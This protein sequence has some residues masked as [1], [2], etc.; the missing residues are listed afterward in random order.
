MPAKAHLCCKNG[1]KHRSRPGKAQAVLHGASKQGPPAAPAV[2]RAH[3]YTR[4]Q[5]IH[6]LL[7]VPLQPGAKLRDTQQADA[8]P[9]CVSWPAAARTTVFVGEAEPTNVLVACISAGSEG[10][11]VIPAP[12]PTPARATHTSQYIWDPSTDCAA[13][14]HELLKLLVHQHTQRS[15]AA[16]KEGRMKT[17]RGSSSF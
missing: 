5:V 12:M 13:H 3:E 1:S 16:H 2:I 7:I 15:Y 14:T 17:S 10:T 4:N 11:K 9:V 6:P 8:V